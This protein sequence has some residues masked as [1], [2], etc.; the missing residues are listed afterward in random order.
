MKLEILGCSGGIG[1]GLKTTTFLLDDTL[2]VDAGTGVEQLSLEQMLQIRTVV[3]SHA[4]LDHIT[5]LPLM[6]ATIFDQHQHPVD[7]YALPDV[8]QALQAHIFNWTI[9]PDYT[10]LPAERPILNLHTLQV[11]DVLNDG[12]HQITAL[13]SEHPTPTIGYLISDGHRSFAFTGDTGCND[14]LWPILNTAKPDLLIIDV[15]FTD[16]V[17][18]LARVSGHLTPSQLKQQLEQFAHNCPIRITHLKPGFETAIM[19]R[20]QQLLPERNLTALL[21]QE[22]IHL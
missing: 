5:G 2:L 19:E 9:W 4:H 12:Q 1:K 14:P 17:Q 16:D 6:L 21:H 8:I 7:V 20:C 11:G 18:E 3:I 13:P 22:T 15:S 10:Q